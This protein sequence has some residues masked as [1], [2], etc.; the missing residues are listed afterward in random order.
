MTYCDAGHA[1]ILHYEDACPFCAECEKHA[2][3]TALLLARITMLEGT[4][5]SLRIDIT[6]I[7]E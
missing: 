4:V 1:E 3:Q 5:D 2:K 6:N 7:A